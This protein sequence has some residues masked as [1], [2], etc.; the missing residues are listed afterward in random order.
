MNSS[1]AEVS[2]LP[3]ENGCV[4]EKVERGSPRKGVRPSKDAASQGTHSME[5]FPLW[6]IQKKKG[7]HRRVCWSGR[8]Y[9]V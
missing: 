2:A 9:W 4:G 7:K 6:L 1:F 5:N 8:Q 3:G